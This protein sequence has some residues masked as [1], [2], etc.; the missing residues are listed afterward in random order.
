[1]TLTVLALVVGS[2]AV[3]GYTACL[4]ILL[5]FRDDDASEA[6]SHPSRPE[7][8]A[9]TSVAPPFP[10]VAAEASGFEVDQQQTV[11]I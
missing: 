11:E 9:T 4:M 10:R 1:M 5:A 6:P 2:I 7:A 8:S 3:V